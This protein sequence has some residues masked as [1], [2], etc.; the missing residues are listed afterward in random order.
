MWITHGKH[1]SVVHRAYYRPLRIIV[2]FPFG[3]QHNIVYIPLS[4]I[5]LLDLIVHVQYFL[6]LYNYML[7]SLLVYAVTKNNISDSPSP[8]RSLLGSHSD[9]APLVPPLAPFTS[10]TYTHMRIRHAP[11]TLEC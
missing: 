3:A 4:H 6:F 8:L 7:L 1:A 2:Y 10:P 5:L 9:C 11:N